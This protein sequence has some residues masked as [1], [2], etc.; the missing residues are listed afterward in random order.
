MF[1]PVQEQRIVHHYRFQAWLV[2]IVLATSAF[3]VPAKGQPQSGFRPEAEA[4]ETG[5]REAAGAAPQLPPEATVLSIDG[6]C[7]PQ[8]AKVTQPGSDCKI[9]V[10]RS[11]F[12]K[13]ASAVDPA[14]SPKAKGQFAESYARFLL[15]ARAARRQGLDKD[16]RFQKLVEL[17]ELQLLAQTYLQA[18]QDKSRQISPEELE[19]FYREN[20]K[21]FEVADLL[22]IYVPGNPS[23]E[24]QDASQDPASEKPINMK[25]VAEKLRSRAVAGED[26]AGLQKE[27]FQSAHMESSPSVNV[28]KMSRSRLGANLQM[29]F[30]LKPGEVSPVISNAGAYFI[31]KLVAKQVPPLESVKEEVERTFQSRRMDEWMK[32]VNGSA[33][34]SLNQE[35][36]K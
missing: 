16:P 34:V 5:A 3:T 17:T 26:F 28:D 13:F 25:T 36:F 8:D 7:P 30:D 2:T 33:K 31:Y 20:S 11:E 32:N 23:A 6:L 27:A 4:Q 18:L 1:N 35:Y 19:K 22:R 10:T 24:E 12:E 14:M 29:V 9:V 15:L 21:L